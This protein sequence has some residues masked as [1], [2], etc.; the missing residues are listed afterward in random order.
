MRM[1]WLNHWFIES[2]DSIDES[3]FQLKLNYHTSSEIVS[4]GKLT[5]NCKSIESW[6]SIGL[7]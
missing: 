3:N 4:T 5:N 2:I 7:N 1:L 6:N